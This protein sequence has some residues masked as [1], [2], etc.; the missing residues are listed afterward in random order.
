MLRN[1]PKKAENKRS[2]QVNVHKVY[3]CTRLHYLVMF[4]TIPCQI[5]NLHIICVTEGACLTIKDMDRPA[6]A[7]APKIKDQDVKVLFVLY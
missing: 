3:M 5:L 2:R 4:T 1:Q 6:A 7:A